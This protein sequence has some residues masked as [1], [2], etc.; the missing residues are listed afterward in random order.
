MAIP[1]VI[2][3]TAPGD[4][5]E[6]MTKAVFQ[7]GIRWSTIEEK[8]DAFRLLFENFDAE[9]VS[10]FTQSD[11]DRLSTDE[12]ILRSPKKISATVENAKTILKLDQEHGGFSNYLRSFK[13]YEQL[14]K[15]LKKRFK[16]MGEMNAYYFL[17]RVGEPVPDFDEWVSTIPGDHPRMK[18]MVELESNKKAR[19]R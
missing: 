14:A 16:F 13:S 15:D 5:L 12:R 18:E 9:K 11:I 6:V 8:W 4:Y 7:A 2:K 19:Q 3:P 10:K 1:E 17:F